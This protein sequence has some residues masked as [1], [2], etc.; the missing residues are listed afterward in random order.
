MIWDQT[1]VLS[2][3]EV[4]ERIDRLDLQF[5]RC[6]LDPLGVSKSHLVLLYSMVKPLHRHYFR[7]QN[8]GLQH[9]PATGRAMIVANHSGGIA[10][11]A[12]MLLGSLVLDLEPP[13][14]AHA[15][16]DRFLQRWPVASS[17][18]SRI[19]QF[20]GLP[21]HA[22]RLLE[23]DRLLMVFP[24]G[25]RGTGK[26]YR[27]RYTLTRFGTGFMRLAL[28]TKTPIVPAA[29]IGGE[30]AFPTIHHSK[31][32]ARLTGAPYVPIPSHLIPLP[33][34]QA[35]E[36]RLGAPLGFE[37]TGR[38]ADDV[39]DAYVDTVKEAIR[40]LLAEGL[41]ARGWPVPEPPR[42]SAERRRT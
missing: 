39:I 10:V 3:P 1:K 18:L 32:L 42:H 17:F 6:G 40:D 35:C 20:S 31:I 29:F 8:H 14:H 24:E 34:P 37:G 30:E 5:S 19:G 25:V 2:D 7:V 9:I 36:W 41:K 4:A 13:R 38:E 15:M 21:E 28:Q 27:D 16:A 33:K 23:L 26:L 22:R 12:L 11:D